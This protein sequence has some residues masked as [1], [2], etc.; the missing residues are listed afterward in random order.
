MPTRPPQPGRLCTPAVSALC[1]NAPCMQPQASPAPSLLEP[2]S[3]PGA[4]LPHPKGNSKH[5]V[6]SGPAVQPP[7]HSC[8]APGHIT[9]SLCVTECSL[10]RTGRDTGRMRELTWTLL[11]FSHCGF[12]VPSTRVFVCECDCMA[13]LLYHPVVTRPPPPMLLS[14]TIAF[15]SAASLQPSPTHAATAIP[16]DQSHWDQSVEGT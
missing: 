1:S 16:G 6:A 3:Q 14:S 4:S 2:A 12:Y 10:S 13:L 11:L 15:S 8:Q 7:V 5:P 9:G